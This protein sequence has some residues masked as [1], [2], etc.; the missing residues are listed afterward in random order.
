LGRSDSGTLWNI[1]NLAAHY[2][3]Q[4]R[5]AE[6][7]ALDEEALAIRRD[8]LGINHPETLISMWG[9]GKDLVLLGRAAEG[10]PVLDDCLKRS[11]GQFVHPNFRDVADVRLRY[12][13]EAVDPAGCRTTAEMW[14]M[15]KRTDAVSLY[16][17]AQCRAVTAA[18]LRER[19][20][21]EAEAAAEDGKAVEWLRQALAKGLKDVAKVRKEEDF[22]ARHRRD[23]LRK[24]VGG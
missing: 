8:T 22:E 9:Y 23:D 12:F 7:L 18:V 16:Q 4:Q 19:G 5:Y 10:I 21:P 15:Q 11:V 6:A 24:L 14:E 13:A 20:A 17:A 1:S 2:R 3:K